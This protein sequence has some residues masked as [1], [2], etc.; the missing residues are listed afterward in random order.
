MASCDVRVAVRGHC[1]RVKKKKKTKGRK[2]EQHSR[3]SVSIQRSI[4]EEHW[5]LSCKLIGGEEKAARRTN[6]EKQSTKAAIVPVDQPCSRSH[7]LRCLFSIVN[8]VQAELAQIKKHCVH[9]REQRGRWTAVKRSTTRHMI[10]L[11]LMNPSYS[12]VLSST[13]D[14]K[15]Y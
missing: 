8:H 10:F 15:L 6:A 9:K 7:C 2:G 12:S 14:I 4:E 13:N 1:H 11:S 3:C 5:T